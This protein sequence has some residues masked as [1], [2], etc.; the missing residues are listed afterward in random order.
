M[1][2]Q[3]LQRTVQQTNNQ[4]ANTYTLSYAEIDDIEKIL[5]DNAHLIS[6]DM[7]NLWLQRNKRAIFTQWN[8]QQGSTGLFDLVTGLTCSLSDFHAMVKSEFLSLRKQFGA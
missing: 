8:R 5:R 4:N 3:A 1:L 6:Q 7:I 2:Y